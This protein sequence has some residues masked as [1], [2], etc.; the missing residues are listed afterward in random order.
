MTELT[1]SYLTVVGATRNFRSVEIKVAISLTL[2]NK[3]Q[4]ASR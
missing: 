2:C 4:N 3:Q 1:A